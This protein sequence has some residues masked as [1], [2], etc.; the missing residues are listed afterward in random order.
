M[1]PN[2]YFYKATEEG[3]ILFSKMLEVDEN[4]VF[5]STK[6]FLPLMTK[7]KNSVL[8][9]YSVNSHFIFLSYLKRVK[10]FGNLQLDEA[11]A[12]LQTVYSITNS[13]IKGFT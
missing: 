7:W 6:F 4:H 9:F 10:M 13:A 1:L 11:N 12:S 2:I 8:S 5:S 3:E